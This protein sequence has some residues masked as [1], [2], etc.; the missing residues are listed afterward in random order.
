MSQLG[1]Q[2]NEHQAVIGCGDCHAVP[3][4]RVGHA[5]NDREYFH[6]I[7]AAGRHGGC[8]GNGQS[9]RL[10][11][12]MRG[13]GQAQRGHHRLDQQA[14]LRTAGYSPYQ[15]SRRSGRRGFRRQHFGWW[16]GW[17]GSRCR[18]RRGDGPQAKSGRGHAAAE[19]VGPGTAPGKAAATAATGKTA[20][21]ELIAGPSAACRI[22]I[23][24][25]GLDFQAVR[26]SPTLTLCPRHCDLM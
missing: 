6:C 1:G 18:H 17:N 8:F 11:H 10:R 3:R 26:R 4:L 2:I 14:G 25:A 16:R 15:G 5:R 7:D 19:Q 13:P 20:A 9:N 23:S 21:A 12:A 24:E 22:R